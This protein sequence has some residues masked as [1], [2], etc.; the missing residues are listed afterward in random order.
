MISPAY[1]IAEDATLPQRA[2]RR[3]LSPVPG[4]HQL[5]RSSRQPE[6]PPAVRRGAPA[7]CTTAATTTSPTAAPLAM[8]NS[9]TTN[10][11]ER[12]QRDRR[13]AHRLQERHERVVR[14]LPHRLPGRQHDQPR[15]PGRRGLGTRS[16]PS[17][18]PT[19]APRTSPA[20]TPRAYTGAWCRSRTSTST[21]TTSIRPTTRHGPDGND[22]VMCL[23]CHRAHASPFSD[24]RAG[25]SAQTFI[26]DSHPQSTDG[27]ASRTTTWRTSTTSTR[28][29]TASA[30]SA[31]SAT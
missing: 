29:P 17:T 21:S 2:G 20:A 25:T 14:E 26:A 18:T 8:G 24:A 3:L 23:T 28:S 19:S 16:R 9:R 1:G 13:Q 12:R 7:P 30:R 6:L 22:Q 4:L 31:T 27:G 5:P 10:V 15:A 11:G